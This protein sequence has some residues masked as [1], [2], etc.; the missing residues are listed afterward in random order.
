MAGSDL[1]TLLRSPSHDSR[2][3]RFLKND[4]DRVFREFDDFAWPVFA[5]HE[6]SGLHPS[7]DVAETSEEVEIVVELPGVN[8]DASRLPQRATRWSL[9]VKRRWR[10]TVRTRTEKCLARSFGSFTRTCHLPFR[11]IRR[12][13]GIFPE[14]RAHG[15]GS[16]AA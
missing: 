4:I 9:P 13:Q 11:W 10:P 5:P 6:D 2:I 16:Q 14:W 15:V 8:A 1:S 7:L 3:F 12:R